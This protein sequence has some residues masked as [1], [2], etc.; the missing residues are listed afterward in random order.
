M[1]MRKEWLYVLVIVVMLA[2]LLIFNFA[3]TD[4][5]PQDSDRQK[6][7]DEAWEK[8]IAC[9]TKCFNEWVDCELSARPNPSTSQGGLDPYCSDV[10]KTCFDMCVSNYNR[11]VRA[12]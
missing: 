6:C 9:G 3:K 4:Y 8:Y 7:I 11:V 1:N 5:S 2:I 10:M 12:C